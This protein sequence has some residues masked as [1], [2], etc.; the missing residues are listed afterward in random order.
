MTFKRATYP[1]LVLGAVFTLSACPG[2]SGDSSIEPGISVRFAE[3]H[4]ESK[5]GEGHHAKQT[6]AASASTAPEDDFKHGGSHG[7]GYNHDGLEHRHASDTNGKGLSLYRIYLV[8]NQLQ[9]VQCASVA[10]VPG[11]LLDRLLGVAYAHGGNAPG[12]VGGRALD[13]PNV[14]DLM[15]LDDQTLVLGDAALAPG[16]YCG[17]RVSLVRLAGG[18]YGKPEFV[19]DEGDPPVPG[20]PDMAGKAFAIKADYCS[21]RGLPTETVPNGPCIERATADV[22]DDGSAVIP[23]FVEMSFDHPLVLSSDNRKGHMRLG[24]AYGGWVHDVDITKLGSDPAERQ[25]VLNNILA[26]VHVD[27]AGLG[28]LPADPPH[29][30]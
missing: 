14:I 30:P 1:A 9:L 3:V 22:I 20:H 7:G 29:E 18:A 19:A 21:Q 11:L 15:A 13:Q 12:P 23:A 25:K 10:R 24:I 6:T 5:D 27:A 28:P 4:M 2:G 16:R 8:L 26:S 17:V